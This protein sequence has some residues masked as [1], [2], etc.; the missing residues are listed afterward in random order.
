MWCGL[1]PWPGP[2]RPTRHRPAGC[3]RWPRCAGARPARMTAPGVKRPGRPLPR[4]GQSVP[5]TRR[6]T[7]FTSCTPMGAMVF[8]RYA[9]AS[10]VQRE[11]FRHPVCPSIEWRSGRS[12]RPI[13]LRRHASS[14]D[15]GG[16]FGGVSWYVVAGGDPCSMRQIP[17][18]LVRS[19]RDQGWRT[20]LRDRQTRPGCLDARLGNL[21]ADAVAPQCPG[22]RCQPSMLRSCVTGLMPPGRA[23]SPGSEGES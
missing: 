15:R 12:S 7:S 20:R 9:T 19:H 18:R 17:A 5:L 22:P 8:A 2:G 16:I 23:C 14:R 10:T 6:S 1:R 3:V 11:T 4:H 13:M 21:G